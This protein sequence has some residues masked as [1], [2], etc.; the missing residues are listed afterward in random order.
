M[1]LVI[2]WWKSLSK[3]GKYLSIFNI[4][5]VL[6]TVGN[7]PNFSSIRWQTEVKIDVWPIFRN[8]QTVV[9]RWLGLD[10]AAL[11]VVRK[12][13][14]NWRVDICWRVP[15]LDNK[16]TQLFLNWYLGSCCF[17]ERNWGCEH[18]SGA[19]LKTNTFFVKG[20]CHGMFTVSWILYTREELFKQKRRKRSSLLFRGR[21]YSIPCRTADIYVSPLWF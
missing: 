2:P 9:C 14:K 16:K 19:H 1:E 15:T 4:H 18:V 20:Q 5:I 17:V 12:I 7:H 13:Y 10:I 11:L 8:L 21:I 6:G 3:S